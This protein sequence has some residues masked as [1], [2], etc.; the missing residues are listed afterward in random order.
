M[1]VKN[2]PIR[3]QTIQRGNFFPVKKKEKFLEIS[4]P[5]FNLKH[6]RLV[7]QFNQIN[8]ELSS[9]VNK[10]EIYDNCQFPKKDL[11]PFKQKH[12]FPRIAHLIFALYFI[13]ILNN[14]LQLIIEHFKNI[15]LYIVVYVT[16]FAIIEPG[17]S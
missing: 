12:W 14:L 13:F 9:H 10:N 4:T 2:K 7:L 16:H 17:K 5:A 15:F 11:G 6:Q 3:P 1:L 8:L